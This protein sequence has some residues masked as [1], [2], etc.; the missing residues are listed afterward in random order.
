MSKKWT[1]QLNRLLKQ[2]GLT[3][4]E[5]ADQAEVSR[6]TLWRWKQGA[7]VKARRAIL[8]TVCNLTGKTESEIQNLI[9]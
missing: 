4:S 9:P 1:K 2:S 5:I 8:L 3:W 6:T 7:K